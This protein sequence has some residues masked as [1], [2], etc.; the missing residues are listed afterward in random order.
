MGVTIS[1]SDEYGLDMRDF[2]F[3]SLLYA[4]SY[5]RSSTTLTAY[6]GSW[7]DQFRGSGFKYDSN[8]FPTAGTVTS[9][10]VLYGGVRMV[11]ISGTSIAATKI[12]A[13][14]KTSSLSDDI[15]IISTALAGHDLIDGG[16]DPNYLRGYAGNDTISGGS[17]LDELYGDDGNDK[18][19]GKSNVDWLYGGNG[20][21]V[22]NGGADYDYL[23]GGAGSDT[24][25]YAGA[26]SGVTVSIADPFAR[27]G[28]ASYDNLYSIENL[29]GSSYSDKLEGDANANILSGG[30]GNDELQGGAGNDKLSGGRGGDKLY[31]GSGYDTAS[32]EASTVGV[33]ASLTNP[34]ANTNE[35]VGD[36]YNSIEALVGSRFNDV[37][38]GNAG[39]NNLFGG[40]GNDTLVGGAGFDSLYGGNGTDTASYAGATAGVIANL[41]DMSGNTNDAT[42]DKYISI[43]NLVGSSFADGLYGTSGANNLAGG[44]GNDRLHSYSGNDVIYGGAGADQLHGGYGA[45][46]FIF[47]ALSDSSATSFDSIFDFLLSEQDRIDLS[48]IDANSKVAGNEAFSFIG[49]SAFTGSGGQ[50]RVVKQSSDTYIYADINGDKVADLTIHLDDAVSLTKDYF[51]L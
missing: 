37:L 30:N 12:A 42:G 29:E 1:V 25:S 27:T 16:D 20:N 7:A 50:L 17:S 28:D 26:S 31:G 44:G 49:S 21:D 23:Y 11:L 47:R 9:Y 5:S 24:A 6:Y 10:A 8:G 18:L 2:D 22:L 32:Y 41:G 13:A 34:S 46:K 48:A 40:D 15:A 33:T 51:V 38:S 3:S 4:N 19:S 45:D 43:E 35:A 39:A 36:T 14:A